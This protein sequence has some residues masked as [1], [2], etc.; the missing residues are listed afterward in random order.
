MRVSVSLTNYS[1]KGDLRRGLLDVVRAADGA[2]VDTVWLPDHLLQADPNAADDADMLEAYTTLGFLAGRTERVRLGTMVTGV[3]FR[4]PA[5]LVKA[6][7]TVDVLSGGRAWLGI[8]AGYHAAEAEAMGL[9]LPPTAERFAR[10]EETLEIARP[11]VGRR[12]H[13]VRGP[14]LRAGSA[15]QRAAA[16][17]PAAPADPHRRHGG[18]AH[19]AAGGPL[20]RRVQPL[21]HSGRGRDDPPQAR[22]AAPGTATRFG[23]PYDAIDKTVSTRYTPGESPAPRLD[24]LAELG[25][26]HAVFITGGP[27]TP[28]DIAALPPSR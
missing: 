10:L 3:T 6:V 26:E 25:I 22:R 1:W 7:T 19:A 12:R 23:R 14:A 16:A 24:A 17:D 9:F 8:G 15:G 11:D 2:G 5:L 13:P 4:P 20:R 18:E 27:W 21:R 28:T